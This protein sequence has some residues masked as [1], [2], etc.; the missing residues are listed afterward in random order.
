VARSAGI[1]HCVDSPLDVIG[2][3]DAVIIP[4]DKG[5]EHLNRARPFIE[6]DLPVFID[7]PLTIDIGHLREF[8]AWHKAGSRICSAS[9]MRYAHEFI[10][11]RQR[12]PEIGR[13]RLIVSTCA[14]SWERYGI[15]ALES[16]YGLL[17]PGGWQDV[18]NTGSAEANLV[19]IRHRDG[20]DVL[21]AVNQDMFGG[22]CHVLI[23]GTE[24]RLD[25]RFGDSFAA[26]KAQ[27]QAFINYARNEGGPVN[28]DHTVEQCKIIVAGIRSRENG[29]RRYDLADL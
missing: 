8:V 17:A 24:G 4:T 27:L 25:A 21:I 9:A 26:F 20:V 3:V 18:C 28:F 11:L 23:F 7:K 6:A 29:G 12:L 19:H 2:Q 14:K 10:D 5:E 15:H 1:E 16:I 13:P 22:F